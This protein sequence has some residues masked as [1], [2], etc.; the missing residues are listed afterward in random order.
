MMIFMQNG[1]M[2]WQT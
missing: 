2:K 1:E